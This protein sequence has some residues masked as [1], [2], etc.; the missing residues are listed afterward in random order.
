[1][2]YYQTN[3]PYLQTTRIIRSRPLWLIEEYL[4]MQLLIDT[5]AHTKDKLEQELKIDGREQC[6]GVDIEINNLYQV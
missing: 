3:L 6:H 4:D 5:Y 2:V 1:M